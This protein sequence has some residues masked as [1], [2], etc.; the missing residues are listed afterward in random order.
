[1]KESLK[2]AIEQLEKTSANLREA[3]HKSGCVE[4]LVLLPII[5]KVNESRNAAA[6]LLSAVQS[7]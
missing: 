4:S 2:K 1:M 5:G 3:L 6:V 7:K